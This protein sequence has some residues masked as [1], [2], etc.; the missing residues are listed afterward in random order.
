MNA[1]TIELKTSLLTASKTWHVKDAANGRVFTVFRE[2]D[3]CHLQ[4]VIDYYGKRPGSNKRVTAKSIFNRVAIKRALDHLVETTDKDR[5]ELVDGPYFDA[6]ND[7]LLSLVFKALQ[8]IYKN[9]RVVSPDMIMFFLD[10]KVD[11]EEAEDDVE[12][13]KEETEAEEEEEANDMVNVSLAC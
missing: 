7:M 2:G 4:Y 5:V 3:M 8:E 6:T 11:E 10:N 9:T 13:D 12:E 1:T